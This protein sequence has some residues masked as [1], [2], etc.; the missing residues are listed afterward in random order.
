MG[1]GI[2][3]IDHEMPFRIIAFVIIQRLGADVFRACGLGNRAVLAQGD[4]HQ[5][6]REPHHRGGQQPATTMP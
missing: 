4:L 2:D 5:D 6:E 1:L 3:L